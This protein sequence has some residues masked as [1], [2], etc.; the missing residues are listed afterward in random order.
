MQHQHS[1]TFI[2]SGHYRLDDLKNTK[3]DIILNIADHKEV[4][5]LSKAETEKLILEPVKEFAI[6]YQQGIIDEIFK[7]TNGHPFF[8]QQICNNCIEKLN[9]HAG[10]YYISDKLLK[11]AIDFS[12]DPGSITVLQEL[13]RSAGIHGQAVLKH[14]SQKIN[15]NI[16][17]VDLNI[18]VDKNLVNKGGKGDICT[19]IEQLEKRQL[20]ITKNT[21]DDLKLKFAIDLMRR[22]IIKHKLRNT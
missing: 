20:V 1:I 10:K 21:N 2:L 13:W 19:I 17:W 7:T 3:N 11:E 18:L 8:V 16:E 5:F 4:G 22:F 14:L 9:E 12:I 6:E 15:Q